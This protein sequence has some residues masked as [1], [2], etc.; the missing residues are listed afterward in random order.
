MDFAF[1]SFRSSSSRGLFTAYIIPTVTRQ[2]QK[3]KQLELKTSI[4]SQINEAV[5]GIIMAARFD[6]V[7]E[8]TDDKDF[9]EAC[10]HW[11]KQ[12]EVIKSLIRTYFP[13]PRIGEEWK[14]Y[15]M[16]ITMVYALNLAD[17]YIDNAFLTMRCNVDLSL[18]FS[19]NI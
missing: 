16:F 19:L 14:K 1:S 3:P 7:T 2:W 18:Y 12:Y 11:E 6:Q 9:S 8:M 17:S 10:I 15:S 13:S 5:T 4:V